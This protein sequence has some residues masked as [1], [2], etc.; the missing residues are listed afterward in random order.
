MADNF[1]E[2]MLLENNLFSG[3]SIA[4][5]R[6][7]F[8]KRLITVLSDESSGIGDIL[9]AYRDALK[10]SPKEL[11]ILPFDLDMARLDD[12]A[13]N[14]QY[15]TKSGLLYNSFHKT[16]CIDPQDSKLGLD[17]I[18]KVYRLEERRH[19][20]EIPLDITLAKKLSPDKPEDEGIGHYRGL[21]QQASIRT[22]LQSKPGSTVLV[23]LPTGT[24]KTMVAHS[25]CLFSPSDKLTL[26]ITPTIALAIEQA[27]RAKVML[28]EAG[29]AI[30]NCYFFGGDQ[31]PQQR[32][33]IKERIRTGQQRILFTS[34][35]SAR[36]ALLP[37]LFDAARDQKLANIIVD[38]AHIV[39]QWGDD[40]RPDFQIFAAVTHALIKE[41]KQ[42][43]K[44]LLL[45][46]TFTD[47]NISTLKNLFTFDENDFIEVHSSFLR[48]EPQYQVKQVSEDD[49][50]NKKLEQALIEL[51]RPLIVYTL[52]REKA[53]QAMLFIKSLGYN[54]T[55]CFTG[56]TST[57]QRSKLIKQWNGDEIDIMVATSAFGVGMD[58]NDVRSILHI[59]PPENIDRFYQEVGRSGRDGRASQSLVMFQYADL[60]K[61]EKI[62]ESTLI[63][64]ELGL[65]RWN[66]LFGHRSSSNDSSVVNIANMH[67]GIDRRSKANE[68][69]NWRT[70]LLMQ[71]SGLINI[72]FKCPV[73]PPQWND[74][75]IAIKFTEQENEFY[76]QYY[77]QIQITLLVDNHREESCWQELV[78]PQRS[79]EKQRRKSGYIGLKNWLLNPN[80]ISLCSSLFQQY[81][82]SGV[83]PQTTCGGCPFCR[84]RGNIDGNFPTLNYPPVVIKP[85]VVEKAPKP[86]YYFTDNKTTVR[87][88][89]NSWVNWIHA[90]IEKKTISTIYSSPAITNRLSSSLPSGMQT[91]WANSITRQGETI[92]VT[93]P[94]L[95]IV[96]PEQSWI[97]VIH[98]DDVFY[99]LL[100]P[101]HV[102]S[103]HFG[104]LWWQEYYD[105]MSLD[106][107]LSSKA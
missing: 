15:F 82:I 34:P 4:S 28:E 88:L 33:D 69:W 43:I 99:I 100:A 38:E 16:L 92:V 95:I 47:A 40:F 66:S 65:K 79:L 21:G 51:P 90:L 18:D 32:Q 17:Q 50:F 86:I 81:T 60:I 67:D 102:T 39:D 31:T 105:A 11:A 45:S 89:I 74:N 84:Q 62:N 42:T 14:E 54:R 58:K 13:F 70:L 8:F 63:S 1:A 91:F 5:L 20:P 22:A 19:I 68:S 35:E 93:E 37:S 25:L 104:R 24:G 61:A 75:S 56:D 30:Q 59:Q 77:Q 85:S 106:H 26:V 101:N 7:P 3:V 6:N 9:T 103:S 46:A 41:S 80:K 10:A 57:D 64:I 29:E 48:P 49:D 2:W 71:R 83:A 107:F 52:E 53:K 36:G 12:L 73:N 96:P 76:E 78:E 55:K 87:K 44:C 98:S 94:S 27:D 23:N 97:P 72:E